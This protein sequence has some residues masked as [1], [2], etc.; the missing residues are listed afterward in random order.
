MFF[1][2]P[3]KKSLRDLNQEIEEIMLLYHYI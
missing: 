3:H 2:Y 1:K